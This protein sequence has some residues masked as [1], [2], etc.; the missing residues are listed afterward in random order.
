[1]L[2]ELGNAV[3]LVLDGGPCT[4]GI[5]STVIDLTHAKPTILRPG[6]VSRQQIESVIGPVEST[7]GLVKNNIAAVSPGQQERH[8]SPVTP[9]LRFERS[10][11]KKVLNQADGVVVIVG[12]AEP[13]N[14]LI[15]L[16][17]NHLSYAREMYQILREIDARQP[18]AIYIEMPPDKPEWAA[19]RDRLIRATKKA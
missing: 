15:C 17:D 13:K 4:V 7:V 3:D 12:P 2:D 1:M 6:G 8:Y 10:Q 16:P 9:A 18:A 5:E 14:N 11:R 19:V